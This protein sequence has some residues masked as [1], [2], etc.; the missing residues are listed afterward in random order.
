MSLLA[1]GRT[2]GLNELYLAV[3]LAPDDPRLLI[4]FG[5]AVGRFGGTSRRS[6]R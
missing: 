6:R 3:Q 2:A 1:L 4:N 5:M